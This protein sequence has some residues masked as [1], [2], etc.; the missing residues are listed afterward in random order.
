VSGWT[1]GATLQIFHQPITYA[2]FRDNESGAGWVGFEFLAE[3]G[4]VNPQVVRL[5]DRVGSPYLAEEVAMCQHFPRMLDK[6]TE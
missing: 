2:G 5:F 1:C 3:V 6:H 4:D